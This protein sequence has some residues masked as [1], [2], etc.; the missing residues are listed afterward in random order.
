VPPKIWEALYRARVRAL[1]SSKS[2]IGE[3]VRR[4]LEEHRR[5]DEHSPEMCR[6]IASI[7]LTML[8]RD[9]DG[10]SEAVVSPLVRAAQEAFLEEDLHIPSVESVAKRLR[11]SSVWLT[12]RFRH[13]TGESPAKWLRGRKMADARKLLTSGCEPIGDIA[14]QLGF[15]S[16]QYFAT[17]FRRDA[18]MTPS[19]FRELAQA[20]TPA[21]RTEQPAGGTAAHPVAQRAIAPSAPRHDF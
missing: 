21:D 1:H 4:I 6:S 18:G 13:E 17:A 9:V 2:E 7:I 5:R 11:V 15:S 12:K 20:G 16:T 3:L 14:V 19:E 10:P 8:A